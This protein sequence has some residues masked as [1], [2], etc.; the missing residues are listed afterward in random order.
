[1]VAGGAAFHPLGETGGVGTPARTGSGAPRS[2]AGHDFSG[3]HEHQGSPQGGGSGFVAQIL[4]RDSR[5]ESR[6]VTGSDEQAEAHALPND[7]LVHL[8]RGAEEAWITDGV[9]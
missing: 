9:V 3:W 7:E 1:M 4:A 6:L 8:Q 5:S 2:G